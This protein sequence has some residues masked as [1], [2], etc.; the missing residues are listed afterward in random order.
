MIK[1][2]HNQTLL[3][4]ARFSLA[5]LWVFTGFTSIFFDYD[6][7]Y[8][9]LV[10]FGFDDS[11]AQLLIY[12]GAILD[13]SLGFWLLSNKHIKLCYAIQIIVIISYTILLTIIEPYYWLHPFGPLSKNLPII[14]LLFL[15]YFTI[16]PTS[17]EK[18]Q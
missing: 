18:A 15:L 2:M 5:F 4:L 3:T 1:H 10:N 7:G 8:E 16:Q 6:T 11:V 17:N 14:M 13:V 12:S 9:L